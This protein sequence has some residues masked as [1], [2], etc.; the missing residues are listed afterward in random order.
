MSISFSGFSLF[1]MHTETDRQMYMQPF[2]PPP[3]HHR[4]QSVSPSLTLEP[5]LFMID[6]QPIAQPHFCTYFLWTFLPVSV[7][8]HWSLCLICPTPPTP[9]ISDRQRWTYLSRSNSRPSYSIK[10]SL[11]SFFRSEYFL[12]LFRRVAENAYCVDYKGRT[13]KQICAHFRSCVNIEWWAWNINFV[14]GDIL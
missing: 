14:S 4:H 13:E 6:T 5:N 10:S 1:Y 7:C 2:P 12:L 8:S 11:I 3:V 9:L